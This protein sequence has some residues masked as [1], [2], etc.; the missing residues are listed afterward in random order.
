MAI[1]LS[2]VAVCSNLLVMICI[3]RDKKLRRPANYYIFSMSLTDFIVGLVPV[4]GLLVMDA[5]K[6]WPLGIILCKVRKSY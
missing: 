4:N 6:G 5:Y 1:L 2:A 3:A